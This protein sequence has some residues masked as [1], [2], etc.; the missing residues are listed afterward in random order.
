MKLKLIYDYKKNNIYRASFNDLAGTVFGLNFEEWY[1]KGGWNDRYICYSCVDGNKVVANASVNK[2]DIIWESKSKKALQIGTVMTHPDYRGKGLSKNLM[3]IILEEYEKQYDFIYLFANRNVL[4][5]Y[6]EFG[7]KK[8]AE[9]QFSSDINFNKSA[10]GNVKKLD[11]SDRDDF[12][13]IFRL[14]SERVPLSQISGVT[15]DQH[16][17]LFYC[18]YVYSDCIYYLEDEDILA[19]FKENE[20]ELLI[21][22]VISKNEIS[23]PEVL[24]KISSG[25]TKK[26]IFHFTPDFSDMNITDKPL[27]D[28]DSTLFIK[29]EGINVRKKFLFPIT[30]RA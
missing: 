24:N 19:I 16:L 1:Q 29:G 26:V 17:L 21:Y 2:M 7:F 27:E 3:N 25:K 12:K 15:N 11:I 10:S 6:P 9:T 14:T 22:D 8:L 13:T 28:P 18:L 30:S 4:N 5:F 20:N 23:I